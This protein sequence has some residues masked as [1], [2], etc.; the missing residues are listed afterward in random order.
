MLSCR[1]GCSP[2]SFSGRVT[3]WAG[4]DGM[5]FHDAGEVAELLG[6][7]E[8]CYLREREWD[9]QSEGGP[10][11]WHAFGILARQGSRRGHQ[12]LV[13]PLVRVV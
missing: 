11:W 1:A 13:F 5:A 3:G 2:G 10:K 7:L 8:V 9:G 6:G 4:P 12:D